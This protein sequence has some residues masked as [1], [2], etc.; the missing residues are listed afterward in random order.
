VLA[1][2]PARHDASELAGRTENNLVVN[3]PAPRDQL[4]R[5]ID[6]RITAA[7]PH[8]LRGEPVLPLLRVA[9]AG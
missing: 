1:E 9:A 5:F 6:V 2:R 4:G 3:F 7:R 8:S